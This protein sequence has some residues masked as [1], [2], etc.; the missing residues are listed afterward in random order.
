M[1]VELALGLAE[2]GFQVFPVHHGE[3]NSKKP[4]TPHGHLDA[5][6]DPDTI[7]DWW[8]NHPEAKVGVPAG[9]N[10]IV[11]ADIDTKNGK[12][13]WDSLDQNWYDLPETFAYDTST[14]GRHFVYKAP[15]GVTLNGQ[16]DY[17]SMAG[18]DRRGGSSWV[19]WVGPVLN[20]PLADA[21][22]WLIDPAE[23][24]QQFNF[25]GDL[26]EWY[27][28]LVPGEPNIIVRR[29]I[30]RINPDMGHSEMIEQQHFAIRAGA[31]GNPGVPALLEAL[32]QAWL[33][34]PAEN[35]TTPESEW[36][37]KFE[38]GL[39]SGLEKYGAI[40]EQLANLPEY[41]INLVPASV[42]D[43]TITE[44]A[45]KA[46]FSKLL[47]ALVKE[48]TDDSR[49]ASI[50]WNAPATRGL[51]REW[52]LQFVF[53]R[54]AEARI[55][56]EPTR[57]NPRL[58]EERAR[59]LGVPAPVVEEP[60]KKADTFTLLTDEERNY[61]TTR[62]NHVD[63]IVHTAKSMNYDQLG[64]FRSVG[65]VTM[66]TGFAFKG[67]IPMSPTHKMGTN[68]WFILPGE[69]GTGKSVTGSFGQQILQTVFAGDDKEVVPY[70]LGDDS[71]PQGLHMALIERDRMASMFSSDEAAGFF[72][73]L[74]LKDWRTSI[75]ER[76]T[77]WYNG[78]VAG[79]N[80]LSQ[81]ELRGKSALTSLSMHMF[82]TPDKL[83]NVIHA[84]MFES[85]FMAR[86]M[87]MFGNP[88]REDSSRF[89]ISIDTSNEQVT[90]DEVPK[91]LKEHALDLITA[92]SHIEHPNPIMPGVG[93]QE[94]LSVAY[95][96]MYRLS[97]GLENWHLV[98]PSLTRLSESMLKMAMLGAIYRN[99]TIMQMEDTLHAIR[100]MEEL[101]KNLHRMAALISQ[102]Q[103]QRRANEIEN[104]VRGQGGSASK[105]KIVYRFRNFIER[106]GREIDSLLT[107]LVESGTFNRS[108][109]GKGVHY[110]INGS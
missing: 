25:E 26:Q 103:F 2:H 48:T 80:K 70:D 37:W 19:M 53:Q 41:S 86:V 30:E 5:T 106:D 101:L 56:P 97:E 6:T 90:F 22:E 3:D 59:E 47:G 15:E 40:T 82:G 87:W 42:N 38:E 110:E 73:G 61:L 39:I 20:Q 89:K 55:R 16:A 46:G 79:S 91:P 81:K 8:V 83:A 54:V 51:A 93:V 32:Q 75:S 34:R 29:A 43:T 95:E 7:R 107:Y 12:H 23:V 78:Y 76:L 74:G 77:S 21:P 65:W 49:I 63:R 44:D 88:P 11:I 66:A 62:P 10:G 13:G 72:E 92:V 96:R 64:Y 35:H 18:V 98:E 94:R 99:D 71:S 104:W 67:F 9:V 36:Q 33:E 102:G 17:R 108:E 105:T 45:G 57:E 1:S 4:L 109:D 50:L 24:K 31:E 84:E 85:G 58:E 28:K 100:A 14:G 52:G 68:L 27:G 60:V 69:S